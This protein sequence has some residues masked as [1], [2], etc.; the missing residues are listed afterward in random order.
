MWGQWQGEA[1]VEKNEEK[2]ELEV[3]N[4]L[5]QAFKHD[6]PSLILCLQF[7]DPSLLTSWPL[8]LHFALAILKS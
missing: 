5:L 8:R 2:S 6:H 3:R 4:V 1:K 7:S